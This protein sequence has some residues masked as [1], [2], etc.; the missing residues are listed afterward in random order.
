MHRHRTA[1]ELLIPNE[2]NQ[3]DASV[4]SDLNESNP[5]FSPGI[6]CCPVVFRTSFDLYH[7]AATNPGQAARSLEAT[8]LHSF[9]V[10][11][12]SG[13]FVYKDETEAIFYM[14]IE[15]R[16]AVIDA[17]GQ[18]ELLVFGVHEPGPSITEQL[19]VLLQRRLLL[20]GVDMLSSVLTKNPHFK[21]KQADFEFLRSFNN[22]WQ[23]LADDTVEKPKLQIYEFPASVTDHCMV[24]IMFRQN[25]C[26]STFFHRLNDIDQN[27]S[28]PSPAISESSQLKDG[29]STL[30]MNRHE[31]T[32]YYNNAPSKLDPKFQGLS[33]L[34]EKGA[35]FCR[36]AGMG[37]AMIEF[38]LVY[39]DGRFV[40]TVDFATPSSPARGVDVVPLENLR[41]KK[42][43]GFG[44][45]GADKAICV[46]IKITDTSLQS[47]ALHEWILLSLNQ[48]LV[49]WVS[50][51]LVERSI[52]RLLKPMNRLSSQSREEAKYDPKREALVDQLCPG[53]PAIKSVLESSSALP[54]PA[55]AKVEYSGV[56]RSSSV[57][58]L[59]LSLLE[60]CILGSVI[61]KKS[62]AILNEE[63]KV[64]SPAEQENIRNLNVIRVSRLQ[65]PRLV[66][67]AWGR[68]RRTAVV[69]VASEDG[70]TML[71]K[72][73]PID[74]PE[75]ICFLLLTDLEGGREEIDTQLRLYKEVV[76]DDGISEKS[77][78]IDLLQSIKKS[79][80][81]AFARSFAFVFSVKRNK[82][83]LWTYNWNPQIVRR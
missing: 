67:L 51:R 65:R 12:R 79:N 64:S 35:E 28:N 40:D 16:G 54:H 31:F 8:V 24:L 7:R 82:R 3:E 77:R 33:T 75:Y 57:A 10:S 14:K 69:S 26:G 43:S 19:R 9:A 52:H 25:L 23:M 29:G 81:K 32:V 18:V 34:T 55:I 4:L 66:R 50:E 74:C 15:P 1:S 22:E 70:T 83:C 58:T 48:A 42:R 20:I 59:T 36:Q 56:M 5:S 53:L 63:T 17:E 39:G 21:W 27:G 41:M 38:G 47:T 45:R 61:E 46:Q 2:N 49:E 44:V 62:P 11:N 72:D 71:I 76:V 6:F 60:K 30:S 13:I 78:S 73:S 80:S 37:I 68:D